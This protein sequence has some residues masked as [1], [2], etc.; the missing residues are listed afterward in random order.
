MA[1]SS[2]RVRELLTKLKGSD[3]IKRMIVM[4]VEAL[5][6][7]VSKEQID[8]MIVVIDKIVVKISKD[9]N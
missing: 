6:K 7:I 4:E 5:E 1:G 3:K 8:E 9:K 2:T